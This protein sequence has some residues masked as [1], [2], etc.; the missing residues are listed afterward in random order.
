MLLCPLYNPNA[1]LDWQ[2]YIV[3]NIIP[4]FNLKGNFIGIA[5]PKPF[6]GENIHGNITLYESLAQPRWYNAEIQ[7]DENDKVLNITAIYYDKSNQKPDWRYLG[8]TLF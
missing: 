1:T 3:Q 8:Y 6:D 5:E 4:V 7:V 2:Y